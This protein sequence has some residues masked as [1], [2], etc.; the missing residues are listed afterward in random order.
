MEAGLRPHQPVLWQ[1]SLQPPVLAEGGGG[2][3]W[4]WRG[5]GGEVLQS[6]VQT[7]EEHWEDHGGDLDL[8][9]VA[10]TPHLLHEVV[11]GHG[12]RPGQVTGDWVCK[13]SNLF[14]F[15][16]W[17]GRRGAA[18]VSCTHQFLGLL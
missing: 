6:S 18:F 8:L 11:E 13:S 4:V 14:P 3:G 1:P 10:D 7:Q 2:R 15:F 17:R 5:S 9:E 16:Q 12:T